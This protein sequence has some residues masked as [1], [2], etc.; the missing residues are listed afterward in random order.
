[1]TRTFDATFVMDNPADYRVLPGM[2]AKIV[3]EHPFTDEKAPRIPGNAVWAD[4]DGETFVW[5]VDPSNST[6]QKRAVKVGKP[7][8]ESLE[9]YEGL[10]TGEVVA[11]SGVSDLREGDLVKKYQR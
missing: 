6:L 9:I 10:K 4:P 3:I 2:T 5:V 8:D 11:T 7:H 1:V